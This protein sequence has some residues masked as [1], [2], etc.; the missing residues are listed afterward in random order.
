MQSRKLAFHS[1]ITFQFIQI[2]F[3]QTSVENNQIVADENLI[4][5]HTVSLYSAIF[6]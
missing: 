5:A 1:I 2:V 4:F 6:I 3:C